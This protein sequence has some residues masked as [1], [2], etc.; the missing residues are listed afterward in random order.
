M[1]L[2]NRSAN[3]VSGAMRA[4]ARKRERYTHD[5]KVGRH[6]ITAD[7]PESHGGQDMGPSP[8]ELLAASLAS[9]TAITME[10]YAERKGWNV[11]GLEVDCRYS[12]AER[13]CP[14]RFEL[15]MRMPAHLSE[16]QVERLQVIAAKCP[17]HRTL[18]GEV[19]FEERVELT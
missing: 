15:I 5:V 11:D 6:V 9:C 8:Q 17:V 12:P 1:A 4:I 2:I 16:E 14:T 10:M 7:E 19:A 13:G 3:A 18:E